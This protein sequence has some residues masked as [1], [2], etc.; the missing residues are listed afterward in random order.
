MFQL[1]VFNYCFSTFFSF[2][3]QLFFSHRSTS[4]FQSVHSLVSWLL[5]GWCVSIFVP[6][7]S[8]VYK[9]LFFQFFFLYVHPGINWH[10][11]LSGINCNRLIS[12]VCLIILIAMYTSYLGI[13]A[14]NGGITP[15]GRG[16]PGQFGFAIQW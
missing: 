9:N 6:Q 10:R 5:V 14:M 12:K 3:F 4:V 2:F 13:F 16:I 1:F 11:L 15:P 8:F 7:M